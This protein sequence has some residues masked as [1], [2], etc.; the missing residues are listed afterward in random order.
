ME[1][2]NISSYKTPT[3]LLFAG[4]IIVIAGIIYAESIITPLLMAFFISIIFAQPIIWMKK[5][6]VPQGLAITLVFILII[7]IFV[8]FGE[9]ISGSLSSFSENAPVYEQN[10]TDMGITIM[11]FFKSKGINLSLG[12]ATS[13][14]DPSKVMN[15]TAGFLGQLGGF[16]GNT[17]TI[18]F[19]VIF[20]LLELDSISA[21]ARA[22]AINT[23]ISI[24][25]LNT[26]GKSIRDYLSIKTVTSL[27]TGI[28]VW[29]SLT[30]LGLDYAIIW[31]LIAF[32]LNYIPNIG[33]IIAAIP[34]VLFALIQ[35]GFMGAMWTSIIF[36]V[37]NML[38]GSVVEPK[39]MGKGMGLSTFVVFASLIFWGFVMGTVGMFLSVPLTMAIKIMLEQNPETKW[40]A[41]ILGT[42]EDA[43]EIITANENNE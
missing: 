15:F 9:L 3:V 13:I 5:K 12:K 27:L 37:A 18:F 39:M 25:Y 38:V 35:L 26:I 19:L 6:K 40:I 21:K 34:A 23:N 30:V 31:A 1:S 36:L 29:I 41:V 8:G 24:S 11:E 17:F 42:Q 43:Q 20:L 33:S 32:L 28:I 16:M 22:I 10:L 7:F 2:K 14:F 4:L